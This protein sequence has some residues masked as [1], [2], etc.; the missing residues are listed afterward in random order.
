MKYRNDKLSDEFLNAL[1]DDQLTD[2]EKSRAYIEINQDDVLAK[3]ACELSKLTDLVR[4]AY[5]NIPTRS[6][7]HNPNRR[8]NTF[9]AGIAAGIAL[10]IGVI[11]GWSAHWTNSLTNNP[12][13][14][15]TAALQ[16]ASTPGIAAATAA[17]AQARVLFHIS[18]SDVARMET[19]LD[20]AE[21]LLKFYRKNSQ[22]ARVEIITNGNGLNLLLIA[23]SPFPDRI[24]QMLDDYPNLT[25]VACQNTIE[26]Y[27]E[28]GVTTRLL[29][30]ILVID[31]GVAEIMRRQQQGW[32][33]IQV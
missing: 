27:S 7:T 31:S 3:R 32:A 29:P 2:E 13:P 19:T 14:T 28:A 23:S 25:F 12:A 8:Q 10:V 30:G 17:D 4:L 18:T 16:N 22:Q 5:K 15:T 26:R 24:K 9:R 11:L 33:Y 20:E 6:Y 21:E 1:V